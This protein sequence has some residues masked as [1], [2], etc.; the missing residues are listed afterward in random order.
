LFCRTAKIS[1]ICHQSNWNGLHFVLPR[2]V[3]FEIY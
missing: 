2:S 3:K 1:W